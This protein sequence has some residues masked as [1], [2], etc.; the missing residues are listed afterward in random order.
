MYGKALFFVVLVVLG[1][2]MPYILA[3]EQWLADI[4]A[5]LASKPAAEETKDS[6][7]S[8]ETN[9]QPTALVGINTPST[10]ATNVASGQLARNP[11]TMPPYSPPVARKQEHPRAI[12]PDVPLEYLLTFQATPEWISEN[13]P[14]VSTRLAAMQLQG[15]RVPVARKFAGRTFAGSLTYYFDH[16]RFV[17]RIVLHGYA[18]DPAPFV[19]VATGRYRMRRLP[20]LA[21]DLYVATLKEQTVGALLVQH[22]SI[23]HRTSERRCEL[24]LE[25]NR[26]GSPYGTSRNLSRVME[27]TRRQLE[28]FVPPTQAK[29]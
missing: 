16:N 8:T 21:G 9:N 23:S 22:S 14:R 4:E 2:V 28:L 17:Q 11:G 6:T 1:A 25:L 15:W 10:S 12:G 3:D 13:W 26:E 18:D 7:D 29:S 20:S 19:A 5:K 24:M 27:R